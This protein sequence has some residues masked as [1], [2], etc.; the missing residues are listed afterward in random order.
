MTVWFIVPWGRGIWYLLETISETVM[1]A[2]WIVPWGRRILISSWNPIRNPNDCMVNSLWYVEVTCSGYMICRSNMFWLTPYIYIHTYIEHKSIVAVWHGTEFPGIYAILGLGKPRGLCVILYF[3]FFSV[4]LSLKIPRLLGHTWRH[5]TSR[6]F[7]HLS[8]LATPSSAE[9]GAPKGTRWR[10]GRY[11][12]RGMLNIRGM[13][14][15]SCIP[16]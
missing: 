3:T 2:W 6:T 9:Y 8:D 13:G 11:H 4:C 15:V 12:V 16:K 14:V 7:R 1:T 5:G 10:S